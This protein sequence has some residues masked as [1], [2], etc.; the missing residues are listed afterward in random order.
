MP[1]AYNAME[2]GPRELRDWHPLKRGGL[3]ISEDRLLNSS[4]SGSKP[5]NAASDATSQ[6]WTEEEVK[7]QVA[8]G[9]SIDEQLAEITKTGEWPSRRPL[10][11]T[12]A[13]IPGRLVLRHR[14]AWWR[15]YKD[16]LA[17]SLNTTPFTI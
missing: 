10:L 16:S 5:M 14:T 2:Y 15:L 12:A 8:L 1:L 17:H 9:K 13:R 7:Q 3:V 11:Q 6:G 4:S